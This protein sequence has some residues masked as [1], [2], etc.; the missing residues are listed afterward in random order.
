MN[1][2]SILERYNEFFGDNLTSVILPNRTKDY[3]KVEVD[4]DENIIAK[5]YFDSDGLCGKIEMYFYCEPCMPNHLHELFTSKFYNF[6]KTRFGFYVSK[7]SRFVRMDIIENPNNSAS[8]MIVF[9]SF[10]PDS[11][12]EYKALFSKK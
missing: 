2:Q 5:Y 4:G 12:K 1:E 3:L 10:V 9:S 11:E 7:Y 6:K 8:A